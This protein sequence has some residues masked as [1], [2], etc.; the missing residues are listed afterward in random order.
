LGG[1]LRGPADAEA[2]KD[3]ASSDINYAPS[4]S[5]CD[6]GI[7]EIFRDCPDCP[8]LVAIPT[9]EF[10]MGSEETPCEKPVHRVIIANSFALGRHEV[11]FDEWDLCVAA[12]GCRFRPEDRGWR[13]GNR[14][15]VD[16]SWD[17][18]HEF[19][20]WLSQKTGKK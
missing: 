6:P 5:F 13:R 14:P 4:D 17:D 3:A 2:A 19:V 9:G 7:R 16:V 11:T 20:T 18:A 15:V 10:K 8:E 12:G 1:D